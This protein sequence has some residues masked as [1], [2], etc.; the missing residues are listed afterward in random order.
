MWNVSALLSVASVALLASV[1]ASASSTWVVIPSPNPPVP[2]G[3]LTAV[4]CPDTI[5]CMSVGYLAG[6]SGY[7]TP[8]AELRSAGSWTLQ[9]VPTPAGSTG[10]FLNAVSC[11]SATTC[12]AVG[13]S[14][15]SDQTQAVLVVR[16]NG[17]SWSMQPA[18]GSPGASF[19]QLWGLSCTSTIS[20]MAVGLSSQSSPNSDQRVLAEAWNGASWSLTASPSPDSTAEL[21]AVSCFGAA[22]CIAV[23]SDLNSTTAMHWDGSVWTILPM[24]NLGGVSELNGVFCSAAKACMAVGFLNSGGITGGVPLT[25]AEQWNGTRWRVTTTPNPAGTMGAF[26]ASVACDISGC[27]AAGY[28]GPNSGASPDLTLVES[29]NGGKWSIRQ[30]PNPS[31]AV[32]ALLLGIACPTQSLC[33]SAG[34]Y[35]VFGNGPAGSPISTLVE[36]LAGTTW[37][38]QLP[39]NPIGSLGAGFN[40]V[41]CPLA[42]ACEAVGFTA[43]A[44]GNYVTLAE[45]WDGTQWTTQQTPSP[46]SQSPMLTG[47]SCASATTCVAVGNY[48]DTNGYSQIFAETFADATWSMQ[49]PAIPQ[50]SVDG[51]LTS[52]S[53]P[54]AFD[55]VAVGNYSTSGSNYL[56][57]AEMWNGSGWSIQSMPAP[58][59]SLTVVLNSLSCSSPS[60]CVA[61]GQDNARS[62]TGTLAETWDGTAW[63]IQPTANPLGFFPNLTGVS[64]VAAASCEAVGYYSPGTGYDEP[65]AEAWDGASWTV[66]NMPT[67]NS[68]LPAQPN[69]ISCSSSSAC[70]AIGF[71][72]DSSFK[73]YT[74]AETWDGS[75]WSLVATPSPA[76]PSPA[77]LKALSCMS[78]CIAVGRANGVTLVISDG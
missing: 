7:V 23:G 39:P 6:S 76:G 5:T 2:N 31:N 19:N 8:F 72:S 54:A 18:P 51:H 47:V 38:I 49:P 36:R 28:Y 55:C 10:S 68:S 67:P 11:T 59:G 78:S 22:D 34:Y 71:A 53:C 33:V 58:V 16:W 9:D 66:Q 24:P 30:T 48:F 45:G 15:N 74:L 4:S 65:F 64:C 46:T 63:S 14:V 37:S 77:L 75:A 29:W 43:N 57:L 13:Y 12:I 69:G 73:D 44:S 56:P 20:C 17:A 62:G 50:G 3:S 35:A 70:T 60:T 1:S 40:G 61:V 32:D 42:G 41:S 21:K 52:V 25:L 27:T 26:L